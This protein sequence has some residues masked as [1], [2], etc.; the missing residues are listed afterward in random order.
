VRFYTLGVVLIIGLAAYRLARLLAHDKIGQPV[1]DRTYKLSVENPGIGR[2]VNS[3]ATCPFCLSVYFAAIGV[4]WYAW[5]IAPTWPGWGE[6]LL[7]IPAAA[8][9]AALA[10]AIDLALTVFTEKHPA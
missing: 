8:G 5:L 1:R 2:W 3:L 4:F 9:V 7:A 10:A 6:T